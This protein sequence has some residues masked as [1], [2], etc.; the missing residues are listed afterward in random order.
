VWLLAAL[1]AIRSQP[2]RFAQAIPAMFLAGGAVLAAQV[3]LILM[4]APHPTLA[5][6]PFAGDITL[7]RGAHAGGGW[8]AT[9][10]LQRD[11]LTPDGSQHYAL[12]NLLFYATAAFRPQD[13]SP[14]FVPPA[15]L[16]GVLVVSRY[17]RAVPLLVLWPAALLLF[18]AGLAEQN[19]RFVLQALPPVAILAGLGL[20]ATWDW[21]VPRWRPA[22]A[23]AVLVGLLAVAGLGL[24]DVGKLVAAHNA[25]LAVARWTAARVPPRATTLTFGITLTL[26]HA[27]S[28]R[29]LDLYGVSR[30]RLAR[31]VGQARPVYV[32]V[33]VEQMEG[34]WALRSPG[35]D[36]RFLRDG[37]GLIRIGG[38]HGY[39][40][41]RVRASCVPRMSR[42]SSP[43]ACR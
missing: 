41:F 7:V 22:L 19:L 4:V 20:A 35:A 40:L 8:S 27:T 31:L 13:L 10:L 37:P 15:L 6:L 30:H 33:Q 32:L 21:I 25:D 14:L 18:D 42:L 28:M 34:Q 39:T 5:S 38:L 23:V 36:Y 9:H 43:P 2:S 29:P 11:F 26:K 1:P 24:R 3:W 16:G 17:R 12:P